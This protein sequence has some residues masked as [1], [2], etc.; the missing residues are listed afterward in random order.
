[1][2]S[3][4]G[5]PFSSIEGFDGGD[6]D[7]DGIGN[8]DHAPLRAFSRDPQLLIGEEAS[9]AATATTTAHQ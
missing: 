6:G 2:P 7:D 9:T 5:S 1:L 3:T 4:K 8:R